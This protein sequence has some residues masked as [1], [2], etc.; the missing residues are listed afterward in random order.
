[1]ETTTPSG[2]NAS[3]SHR[4]SGRRCYRPKSA[5]KFT[6]RNS[7]DGSVLK[8]NNQDIMTESVPPPVAPK[9]A[10]RIRIPEFFVN[11]QHGVDPT[12]KDRTFA[13]S[14]GDV[15]KPES[16]H[17]IKIVSRKGTIRG[18]K[19]RVRAGIATFISDG[20]DKSKNYRLLEKGRIV[21]FTTSVTIVRRTHE[22]CKKARMILQ[23]HMV[24]FEEKDL[25]MSKE[26]QKEL[27]ERLGTDQVVLPQIYAD[28]QHLG[29][30]DELESI[31]ETGKL[32][33]IF[34]HFKKIEKPSKCS[35]CGGYRLVPC[36]ICSGSKK[37]LKRNHFT[38]ELCDLKCVVCDENGLVRCKICEES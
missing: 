21:M 25:F 16:L 35:V 37:S 23:N 3:Q 6:L 31:N 33:Q 34:K 29:S 36:Q 11:E 24:E 12:K 20:I 5:G 38:D 27:L 30:S 32:R 26:Y 28:G 19:D 2:L 4:L 17:D 18:V 9:P 13:G 22:K 10:N 7:T 14:R 8:A 15:M 1:M